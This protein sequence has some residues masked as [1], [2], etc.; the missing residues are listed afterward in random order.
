MRRFILNLGLVVIL[1]LFVC[2]V[3]PVGAQPTSGVSYSAAYVTSDIS[4]WAIRDGDPYSTTLREVSLTAPAD[5]VVVVTVTGDGCIRRS[6][7]S[8]RVVKNPVI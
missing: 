1:G 4:I 2:G 7:N 3:L 6:I 8:G 5:G